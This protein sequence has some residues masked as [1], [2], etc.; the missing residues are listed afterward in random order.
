MGGMF[1]RCLRWLLRL[2]APAHRGPLHTLL[3]ELPDHNH[4]ETQSEC[5][6][7]VFPNTQGH[8]HA[9]EQQHTGVIPDPV[10]GSNGLYT[11]D[12]EHHALS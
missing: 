7:I 8:R 1:G 10:K 3:K 11:A 2:L 5:L 12:G 6:Y 4:G 9:A